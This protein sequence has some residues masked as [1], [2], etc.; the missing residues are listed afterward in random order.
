MSVDPGSIRQPPLWQIKME[1]LQINPTVWRMIVIPDSI[2]LSSKAGSAVSG[3]M[4]LVLRDS[5]GFA[6]HYWRPV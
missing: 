6:R 2:R 3:R 5:A 1:L 4:S